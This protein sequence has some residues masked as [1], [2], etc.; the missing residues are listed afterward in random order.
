MCIVSL[1]THY[2]CT[3]LCT[4]TQPANIPLNITSKPRFFD[5]D[6][7]RLTEQCSL[8]FR[9]TAEAMAGITSSQKSN[10]MLT[11]LASELAFND[12]RDSSKRHCKAESQW[13]EHSRCCDKVGRNQKWRF[14]HD[15]SG[16]R[17]LGC[18]RQGANSEVQSPQRHASDGQ[19]IRSV[20]RR[21]DTTPCQ[22]LLHKAA[23]LLPALTTPQSPQER[24]AATRRKPG[25]QARQ[26]ACEVQRDMDEQSHSTA[27]FRAVE[28]RTK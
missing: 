12:L 16:R 6:A 28:K 13:C 7:A 20:M 22:S 8:P 25:R 26:T 17:R 19:R 3:Q 1:C 21:T 4:V 5:F 9:K 11:S 2:F 24:V 10:P 15:P 23:C 27:C 18:R 14:R